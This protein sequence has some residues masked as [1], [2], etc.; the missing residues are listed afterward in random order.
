M[1][2][3]ELPDDLVEAQRAFYAADAEVQRVTAALPSGMDVVNATIGV[4]KGVQRAGVRDALMGP[5]GVV[6]LLELPQGME[7][8]PLVPDQ[9]VV[10]EFASAGLHPSLH[11]RVNQRHLL[12]ALREFETFYNQ[13]RPHRTLAQA[14][15]LRPL[16]DPI[17]DRAR[18]TRL[19]VRRHDRLGG[20]L[21]QYSMQLDLAG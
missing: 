7:E 13:H 9:R 4:G 6:E 11:E 3:Y 16:P 5:V 19:D 10:E 21:S 8:V 12:H 14:A 2:D 1:A 17:S 18:I 15:P 20:V